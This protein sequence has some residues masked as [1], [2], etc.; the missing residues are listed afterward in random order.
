MLAGAMATAVLAAVGGG[1]AG[2][3]GGGTGGGDS[4]ELRT[5]AH[6]SPPSA[7]VPS[8]ALT[9]DKD[10]VPPGARIEV[11][12]N[13][14]RR[15]TTVSLHVSGVRPGY[16]FGAHVHTKPCAKDPA[17]AG[18]HYQNRV[19]PVQPSTDPEYVNPQNEVWLDFTS[20]AHGA[21]EARAHHTWGFRSGQ[22]RS[23]VLHDEPGSKG[24]RVAC[25]TVPFGAVGGG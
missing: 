18:G 8:H 6:F 22:A 1:P 2:G 21:G 19:D 16:A 17:A 15:G 11:Q 3:E 20:D 4:F 5:V 12:Q 24:A 14:D 7:T 9:Y 13:S 10:L 23:V 25:L